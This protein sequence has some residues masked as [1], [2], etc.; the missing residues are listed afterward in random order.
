MLLLLVLKEFRHKK[1]KSDY[2]S[3]GVHV[4]ADSKEG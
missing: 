2:P 3:A 1:E 4:A